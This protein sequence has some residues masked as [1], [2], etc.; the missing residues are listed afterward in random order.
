MAKYHDKSQLL[1]QLDSL[2][3]LP[4]ETECVEFKEAKNDY[5]FEKL[6]KYFSALSNEASLKQQ[7]CGW[8]LFGVNDDHSVWGN[9]YH[10]FCCR[11]MWNHIC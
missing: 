5:D 4:H 1:K 9:R 6:G 10:F 3:K 2:L 11:T 8:L 7:K